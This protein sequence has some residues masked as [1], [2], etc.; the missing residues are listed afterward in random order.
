MLDSM[1]EN[2]DTGLLKN[3]SRCHFR[4]F[5]KSLCFIVFVTITRFSIV[6][7]EELTALCAGSVPKNT[8]KSTETVVNLYESWTCK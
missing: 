1:W 6:T 3:S 8:Q 5:G 2:H 7:D 4:R